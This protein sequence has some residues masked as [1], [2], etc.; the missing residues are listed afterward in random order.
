MIGFSWL[1]PPTACRGLSGSAM[2]LAA[3]RVGVIPTNQAARL[4]SV[5]PV[6]PAT[7]RLRNGY[8]SG[9]VDQP[10]QFPVAALYPVTQRAASTAP[11]AT[12]GVTACVHCGWS[13]GVSTPSTPGQR[14]GPPD[15]SVTDCTGSGAPYTPSAAM[16][17][18]ASAISR[19]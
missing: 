11:R 4:S 15:R 14:T 13:T 3:A 6:L 18:Y 10:P 19:A 17:A 5:V 1:Y 2:K 12:A 9:A 7:G 8:T 16:V